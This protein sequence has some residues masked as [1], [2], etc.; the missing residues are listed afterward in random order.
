MA[1]A[2][3]RVG[4]EAL[5]RVENV[6]LILFKDHFPPPGICVLVNEGGYVSPTS[7]RSTSITDIFNDGFLWAVPKGR[8]SIE[9]RL[10]RKFGFPQYDWKM[11][12]PK[13][14]LLVCNTCGHHY[15]ANHLCPHCYE[16]VHKETEAMQS[17]IQ[18]ELGL[19]PIEKEVVVLFDGEKEEKPA[20]FWEVSFIVLIF[21]NKISENNA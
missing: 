7:K 13:K 16:K 6:F 19:S 3:L 8:R 15:E 14:N 1:T 10:S 21:C 12:V 17:A 18:E 9:R 2:L 20:E 4:A 5:Q 11:L